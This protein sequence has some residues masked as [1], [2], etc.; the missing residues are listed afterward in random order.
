MLG[1][2]KLEKILKNR[3]DLQKPVN[4]SVVEQAFLLS[5][6]ILLV[7]LLIYISGKEVFVY[8]LLKAFMGRI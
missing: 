5:T 8:K 1:I 7:Y 4:R 3:Y 2:E 6:L